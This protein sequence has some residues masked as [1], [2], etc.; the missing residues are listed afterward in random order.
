MQSKLKNLRNDN[1][2]FSPDGYPAART[3]ISGILTPLGRSLFMNVNQ[4]PPMP[5]ALAIRNMTRPE[6][7]EL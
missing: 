6:V 7:D 4:D 2:R 3:I 5:L 1:G